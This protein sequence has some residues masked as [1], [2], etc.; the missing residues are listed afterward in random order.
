MVRGDR[1]KGNAGG[2]TNRGSCTRDRYGSS[3]KRQGSKGGS[4]SNWSPQRPASKDVEVVAPG[5]VRDERSGPGHPPGDKAGANAQGAGAG[6]R[7]DGGHPALLDG[8][9]VLAEQ[10]LHGALAE[11]GQALDGEVL[12]KAASG[13]LSA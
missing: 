2:T 1:S 5:G 9:V 13:E 8:G 6:E 7:L 10:Q 3:A 12:L 11:G 4:S